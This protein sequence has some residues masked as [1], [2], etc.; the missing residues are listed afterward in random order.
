MTQ[1][2]V[3][4]LWVTLHW[5]KA[6]Y[7]GVLHDWAGGK[8][9]GV[10]QGV[11]WLCGR[12]PLFLLWLG[13]LSTQPLPP[14]NAR[15]YLT[16]RQADSVR[17]DL[18]MYIHRFIVGAGL[19]LSKKKWEGEGKWEGSTGLNPLLCTQRLSRVE[20]W[21]WYVV[22]SQDQSGKIILISVQL[23]SPSLFNVFLSL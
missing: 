3:V 9:E 12:S 18:T 14:L 13:V 10:S 19:K 15:L 17:E 21:V 20:K 6:L 4:Q 22:A 5:P 23:P 2:L 8:A 7:S 16:W 11:S 1:I